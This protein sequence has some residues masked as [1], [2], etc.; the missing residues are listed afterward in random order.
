MSNLIRNAA[1]LSWVPPFSLDLTN[2]DPDIVYCVEV[3]NI[4]CGRSHVISECDVIETSYTNDAL[5]SGYIYECTVT[6][7]SNVQGAA[8][9]TRQSVT[10]VL[11]SLVMCITGWAALTFNLTCREIY[12]IETVCNGIHS[13]HDEYQKSCIESSINS[14]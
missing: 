2:A 10:G 1:V 4:T 3:Y 6:P 7:R 12:V 13:W 5:H 8:N 11:L 14:Q 9:G